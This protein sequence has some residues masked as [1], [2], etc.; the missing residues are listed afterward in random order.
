M[1]FLSEKLWKQ[2]INNNQFLMLQKFTILKTSNDFNISKNNINRII[3]IV[4]SVRNLRSELNIPYKQQ[5]N[6]NLDIKD[7]KIKNFIIKYENEIK[8][9]LKV[10][11][12]SYQNLHNN[13]KAAFIVLSDVSILIPLDGI[14]D[15]NKEIEKLNKKRNVEK[16]KLNSI[17]SKLINKNFI[18]KAPKSVVEDFKLQK[19]N[20]NS[21]IEKIDQ[22]INTIS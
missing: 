6:L 13:N 9:F 15:T 3:H 22:I 4:T 2:L 20:L 11:K 5:I 21:S 12:I 8:R 1:P 10:D 14:V 16:Q 18:D 19:N 17:E 7:I